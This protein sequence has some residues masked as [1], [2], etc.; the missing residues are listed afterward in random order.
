MLPAKF[1]NFDKRARLHRKNIFRK[2]SEE[3]KLK[4]YTTLGYIVSLI[5]LNLGHVFHFCI[6]VDIRDIC[7]DIYNIIK[8]CVYLRLQDVSPR[9]FSQGH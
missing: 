8:S 7:V 4:I 1:E 2:K 9:G 5:T 6:C 3:T